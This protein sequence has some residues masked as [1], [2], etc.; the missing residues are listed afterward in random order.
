MRDDKTRR[1]GQSP[2][3]AE[4]LPRSP[5]PSRTQG[6]ST[7]AETGMSGRS[8]Q[9]PLELLSR[10]AQ[11]SEARGRS[12]QVQ[13]LKTQR[14]A[15]TV[16]PERRAAVTRTAVLGDVDVDVDKATGVAPLM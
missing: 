9:E 10:R 2:G 6:D 8:K 14:A 3:K 7:R 4:Y 1:A 11:Q 16:R 15:S 13:A 5:R 12:R